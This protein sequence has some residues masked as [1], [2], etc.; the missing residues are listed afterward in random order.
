MLVWGDNS[1]GQTNI[2]SGVANVVKIAGGGYHNIVLE[3]D[4]RPALTL[5]PVS[6]T[7]LA[8]AAVRLLAMAVGLQP[9]SYQWFF[10]GTNRLSGATADTLFLSNV[11]AV[12][13]GNY[14]VVITNAAGSVTSDVA[15][16]TVLGSPN[17][18]SVS[19]AGSEVLISFPSE[20]GLSYTLEYKHSLDDPAWTPLPPAVTGTGGVMVLQ[21][22]NAPA[23]SRYYRL[24]CE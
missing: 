24:R 1:Y 12:Q 21:D 5:Q 13:A 14:A 23:D 18:I 7:A 3:S 20:T 6:Q 17:I 11:Q 8:G 10:D 4:G 2:P 16:L 15:I 19:L 22:S 9:L